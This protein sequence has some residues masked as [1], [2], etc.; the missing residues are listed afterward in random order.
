M[1][2]S[3]EETAQMITESTKQTFNFLTKISNYIFSLDFL[4]KI[5]SVALT[6][7][8]ITI[9]YKLIRK[10]VQK[11]L[12]KRLDQQQIF[13]VKKVLKYI[14]Y[15]CVVLYIASLFGVKLSALLGAAG[16]AGV[17]IG[18]AAQTSISNIISG[19]FLL[20]ENAVRI[21]DYITVDNISGTVQ[22]VDLLSVKIK[23]PD[24]Q[25]VRIPN[26][27]IIKANLINTTYNENRRMTLPISVSYDTDNLE[28]VK[29]TLL[30]IADENEHI[31]K[32]PPPSVNFD[33]FGESSVDLTL[34][35]WFDKNDFWE[36]KNSL[37]PKIFE[38]FKQKNIEIPYKQLDVKIKNPEK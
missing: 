24:N 25:I 18:F 37:A 33:K 10:S 31:L 8:V 15:G 30:E 23:T 34:C 27:T 11:G 28:T 29:N 19:V 14:Y 5:L 21:G 38:V 35:V 32:D 17:A 22:S 2:K 4:F 13:I 12:T 7:F 1:E 3:M 9:A 26:E 6:L 16:I 36:T 20:G